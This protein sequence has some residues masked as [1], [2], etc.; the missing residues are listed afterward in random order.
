VRPVR[1][2]PTAFPPRPERRVVS[3]SPPFRG[4]TTRT[5]GR[6]GWGRTPLLAAPGL[7]SRRFRDGLH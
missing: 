6:T 7:R 2:R 4:R 5:H 3:V 1:V